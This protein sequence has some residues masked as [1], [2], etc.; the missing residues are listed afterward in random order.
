MSCN[1]FAP[2]LML[3]ASRTT[4][5]AP[6]SGQFPGATVDWSTTSPGPIVEETATCFM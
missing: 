2:G 3:P 5:A 1:S 6:S 4:A